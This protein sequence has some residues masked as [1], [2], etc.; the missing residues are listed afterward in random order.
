MTEHLL[1]KHY[2]QSLLTSYLL[3][4][5]LL[6]SNFFSKVLIYIQ[7]LKSTLYLIHK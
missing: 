3:A 1:A 6:N 5:N 4:Q 7:L 2:S